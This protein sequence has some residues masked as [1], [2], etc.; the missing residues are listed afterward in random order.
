MREL[1]NVFRIGLGIVIAKLVFDRKE[2]EW[3]RGG[4]EGGREGRR[5]E[6]ALQGWSA[7]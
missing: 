6:G 2:T 1:F 7:E 3:G 5:E 4:E